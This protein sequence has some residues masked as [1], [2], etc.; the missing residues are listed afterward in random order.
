MGFFLGYL[1]S[2]NR[3]IDVVIGYY[4]VLRSTP[5]GAR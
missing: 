2:G 3:V 4:G 1:H 5:C